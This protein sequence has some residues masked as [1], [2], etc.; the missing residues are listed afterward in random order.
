MQADLDLLKTQRWMQQFIIA[1]GEPEEGL[2]E[3]ARQIVKPSGTL[4]SLER[5]GVYRGMYLSR[6]VEAL[7]IDYPATRHFLGEEPFFDLVARYVD[8]H[9]S[10]SYNLNR[11]GDRFPEFVKTQTDLPRHDFVCDL[12]RLELGLTEVFDA[13]E[14]PV[15]TAEAIAA[16]PPE[17]WERARLKP[18]AA[19]RLLSFD[20][21]V[22]AYLGGVDEENPFPRIR[23][24]PTWILAYRHQF[25]LHRSALSRPAF[26]LLNA[27]VSGATVGEA[28]TGVATSQKK[29]YGWFRDWMANGLFQSVVA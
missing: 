2:Q 8:Q 7:E 17:T 13:E 12:T 5:V 24:Q 19:L 9:P 29:V 4:T 3:T 18:I 15:L 22:S 11:L 6:L 16:V 14:T 28:I 27:L 21:P 20:Y 1:P 23:K 25:L 26:Q 10:R